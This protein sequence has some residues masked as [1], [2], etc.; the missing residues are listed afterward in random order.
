MAV[1]IFFKMK[2]T[3]LGLEVDLM[4]GKTTVCEVR[5]D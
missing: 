4:H 2:K 5:N 1:N 3:N